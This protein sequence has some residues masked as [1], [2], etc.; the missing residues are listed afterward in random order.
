MTLVYDTSDTKTSNKDTGISLNASVIL[1]L[2]TAREKEN[3]KTYKHI[4]KN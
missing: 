3:R 1:F 4:A 2:S